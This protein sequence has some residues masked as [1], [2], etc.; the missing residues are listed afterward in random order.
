MSTIGR[1]M[2]VPWRTAALL[3]AGLLVAGCGGEGGGDVEQAAADDVR[4]LH[5]EELLADEQDVKALEQLRPLVER[6]NA[7]VDDLVRAVILTLRGPDPALA[8]SYLARA[9]A[10][11]PAHPAVRYLSGLLAQ[12]DGR[13]EQAAAEYRAVLAADP[14]DVVS[15]YQLAECLDILGQ[16]DEAISLLRQVI[17]ATRDADVPLHIGSTYRLMQSLRGTP[18][19][20]ALAES[21]RQLTADGSRKSPSMREL[22]QRGW[23]RFRVPEPH[24]LPPG[25]PSPPDLPAFSAGA[26]VDLAGAT[27]VLAADVDG[28]GRIDLVGWGPRGVVL[29]RQEAQGG[30]SVV[31]VTDRPSVAVAAGDIDEG[32]PF[33]RDP[34]GQ[35]ATGP[36]P[37]HHPALELAC[38]LTPRGDAQPSLALFAAGADGAWSRVGP[39][40]APLPGARHVLFSDFDHDSQLDLL[41]SGSR[42]VSVLRNHGALRRAGEGLTDA[43]PPAAAA[44]GACMAVVAEDFDTD[45]DVDYLAVGSHGLKLLRNLRGGHFEDATAAWRVAAGVCAPGSVL[46]ADIDADGRADLLTD[47]LGVSLLRGGPDGFAPPQALFEGGGGRVLLEDLD[48]DGH[49][50]L[51]LARGPE[52]EARRGPLAG[53]STPPAPV[54]LAHAGFG[55]EGEPLAAADVDG[56]L[57]IDLVVLFEGTATIFV[58]DLAGARGLLVTLAGRKDNTHGV[59]TLVELRAGAQYRR[60]YTRGEP[61]VLGLGGRAAGDVLRLTWPNGVVQHLRADTLAAGTRVTVEQVMRVGGSCPFLYAW[62]GRNYEFITDALGASP[63]GLP[64]APGLMVPWDS[65]EH[66]R[67]RGEQL[68]P[69]DGELRIVLTEELREVTYLD[70]LAL[71]AIDH[72][73]GVEIQP[74]E[75]FTFPP[76]PEQHVHTL[77]DVHPVAR[78][79]ASNGQDVTEL[80]SAVDDRPAR[81]FRER[82]WQFTGLAEPWHVDLELAATPQARAALAAAPKIRLAVTGWLQWGDASVNLA[83]ARHPEV[84]FVPP[85]LWVPEGDDPD[86]AARPWRPT[87]PP[88][89]FPAGKTKTMVLDVTD[90]VRRDDPRIRMTTTLQLS[91]DAVRV[92]LDADDAPFSDTRLE[93]AH[94]R[95][96]FRG[97]SWVEA[98]PLGDQPERFDYADLAEPRWNQHPGLYTRYGSVE[99]LLGAAD[100]MYVIFGAGDALWAAFDATALPPVPDGWARDWLLE[101]DGWA[102]DGDPNTLASQSVEPLPFHGMSAYPPP[103][104]EACPDSPA[105]R[106]WRTQWNTRPGAV[107]LAPLSA[108]R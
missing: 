43:T 101:L 98:N 10:A 11:E 56:D 9:R 8:A 82:A 23:G 20:A 61:L 88:V 5:A 27:G 35:H 83:A 42:G 108:A 59:G 34:S 48:L 22:D 4:R 107:L 2:D 33:L 67:L 29:A 63:L 26:R 16:G 95:L 13:F 89:G 74:N 100:D 102:K 15:R 28:D 52:L 73:A 49:A 87:G 76:H 41:V 94:A 18:E 81:P 106:H 85:Q 54:S 78:A 38:V 92:V 3:A 7:S 84:E 72:P 50:D 17:E 39:E 12:H 69:Q 64:A 30:F 1:W 99:P 70:R 96:G 14:G 47:L 21:F 6:T 40:V 44:L 80:V 31:T 71:H 103:A 55:P 66:L 24:G 77:R 32:D 25:A 51:L 93:V 53:R 90:V 58:N 79:L 62:N 91:L 68:V 37:D 45:N 57:D 60:D 19:S 105:H 86:L 75:R 97:F 46:A 65:E 104:G 36:N